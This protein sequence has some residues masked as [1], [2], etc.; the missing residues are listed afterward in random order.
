MA[1]GARRGGFP[2]PHLQ[3]HPELGAALG[4]HCGPAGLFVRFV[5]LGFDFCFPNSFIQISFIHHT[6]LPFKVYS[7]AL[8]S[9]FCVVQPPPLLSSRTSS[10]PLRETRAPV[11]VTP[12]PQAATSLLSI[13]ASLSV[14]DILHKWSLTTCGLLRPA[15]F[16]ERSVFA[17]YPCRSTF[18]CLVHLCS[19]I[20]L[21]CTARPCSIR[22]RVP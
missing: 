21:H 14:L 19:Q 15:P 1:P 10:A 6:V 2:G 7:S 20:I 9:L 4:A 18:W 13:S 8:V 17:V 22:P 16:T 3:R 11:A 5:F 12:Q